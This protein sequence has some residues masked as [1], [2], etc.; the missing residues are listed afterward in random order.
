MR[1]G[2]VGPGRRSEPPAPAKQGFAVRSCGLAV[3]RGTPCAER[4]AGRHCQRGGGQGRQRK[5]LGGIE[6][7]WRKGGS[8]RRR[9]RWA[10]ATEP[11]ERLHLST[12]THKSY[13]PA[14]S[15]EELIS[16]PALAPIHSFRAPG[17][18]D[19]GDVPL[20]AGLCRLRTQRAGDSLM[21]QVWHG[22]RTGGSGAWCPAARCRADAC[23]ARS[24]T[25]RVLPSPQRWRFAVSHLM[26]CL[27]RQQHPGKA[28]S[29]PLCPQP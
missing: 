13:F 18:I 16:I 22:M 3:C 27:G 7:G 15:R 1:Y 20:P 23:G 26:G 10:E 25:W 28:L 6:K 24:G 17:G 14:D 19:F 8:N 21:W 9:V 29:L 4:R 2:A 11:G 5:G 12:I